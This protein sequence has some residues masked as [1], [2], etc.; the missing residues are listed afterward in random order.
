MLTPLRICAPTTEP[1]DVP[2]T[3]S[4]DVRSMPASASPAR[5]P[6]S[7][8]MPV[9]P[10]PPSTSARPPDAIR[11]TIALAGA[12]GDS[13]LGTVGGS[14][15]GK[16]PIG[17]SWPPGDR[18]AAYKKEEAWTFALGSGPGQFLK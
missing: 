12:R 7:Q 14:G 15:T 1:A 5:R 6:V 17:H 16:Q 10:P 2:T 11:E 18:P 9:T 4:A 3:R 13:Q 8:A